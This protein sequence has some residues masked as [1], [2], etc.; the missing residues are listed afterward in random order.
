MYLDSPWSSGSLSFWK[1]KGERIS[2]KKQTNNSRIETPKSKKIENN[3]PSEN[4]SLAAFHS[5]NFDCN[6]YRD[7]SKSGQ[8][9][10]SRSSLSFRG[11]KLEPTNGR[12]NNSSMK[13]VIDNANPKTMANFKINDSVNIDLEFEIVQSLQ[14]GHGG[15]CEPMF[16]VTT[17]FRALNRHFFFF[18][19]L[20]LFLSKALGTTGIVTGVDEDL[21]VEVTFPSGNKW[22]FNP[23]ILTKVEKENE[24]SLNLEKLSELTASQSQLGGVEICQRRSRSSATE[25]KANEFNL[26]DLVRISTDL[27]KI[28]RAQRGHGEWADVM[29]PV[30]IV[31]NQEDF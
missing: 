4:G 30:R 8:S 15:W 29:L 3:R 17:R 18:F 19:F 9:V 25:S 6:N 14:V 5:V 26:N 2:A 24:L 28:K 11:N 22:T 31:S 10:N 13:E 21:D 16:E 20:W 7:K 12:N 1:Q 23:A 27:D